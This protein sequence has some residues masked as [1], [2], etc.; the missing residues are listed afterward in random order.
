M[1]AYWGFLTDYLLIELHS[2]QNRILKGQDQLLRSRKGGGLEMQNFKT[3][4]NSSGLCSFWK[5]IF[6]LNWYQKSTSYQIFQTLQTSLIARVLRLLD[7][8][9]VSGDFPLDKEPG[10]S[11]Y[12]KQLLDKL[13]VAKNRDFEGWPGE[14]AV[15]RTRLGDWLF[16]NLNRL[17]S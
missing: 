14:S 11:G 1:L 3:T 9:V 12:L 16:D 4:C 2:H 7:P 8:R 10:D 6:L 5:L 17:G 13:S 15:L